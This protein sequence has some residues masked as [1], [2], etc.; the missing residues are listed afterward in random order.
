[1]LLTPN[2]IRASTATQ[3]VVPAA[4]PRARWIPGALGVAAAVL[5][6]SLV[7]A[8][9]ST[10]GYTARG[11]GYGCS[12]DGTICVGLES[13]YDGPGSLSIGFSTTGNYNT[14]ANVGYAVNGNWAGSGGSWQEPNGSGQIQIANGQSYQDWDPGILQNNG[15]N[16]YGGIPNNSV[17]AFHAQWCNDGGLFSGSSCSQWATTYVNTP[18]NNRTFSNLQLNTGNGAWCL[19]VEGGVAFNGAKIDIYPCGNDQP[20]QQ[21]TLNSN[22]T[23]TSGLGSNWCLDLPDWD[24]ADDTQLDLW[25]CNGGTNQV[26][27]YENDNTIRGYYGKCVN[28]AGADLADGEPII[29]WDCS[30]SEPWNQIWT[31][32]TAN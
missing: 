15:S 11:P 18:P 17:I 14:Y 7:R 6:P 8:D 2:V 23:I 31:T 9:E 13:Y 28:L 25:T 5:I 27:S 30:Q 16:G 3:P 22:G 21:W 26:W 10:T 4:R 1:M 12:S 19:D 32:E 20:N 24:I 29:Y